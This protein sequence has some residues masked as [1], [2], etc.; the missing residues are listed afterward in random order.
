MGNSNDDIPHMVNKVDN[1][2]TSENEDSESH[3]SRLVERIAHRLQLSVRNLVIC[4][5]QTL[6]SLL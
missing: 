5:K 3:L 1:C 6:T 4:H 2:S